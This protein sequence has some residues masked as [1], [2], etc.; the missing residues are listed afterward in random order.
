MTG[1]DH[2][3]TYIDNE[4]SL[5]SLTGQL[6]DY[7]RVALDTEADS[8]YHYHEKVCLI[9]LAGGRDVYIVDPL[10]GIDLTAFFSILAG[11]N[12]ILH[13]ADYDL[14]MLRASF[15]FR[16]RAPIFDTMLAARLLGYERLGLAALTDGILGVSLSK[17]SQ[18]FNWSRRPLPA[19]KLAYAGDDTRYLEQLA[20]NLIGR[21]RQL[22]REDWHR[23]SCE[24]LVGKTGTD[25]PT[26]KA[27]E[28]WRIKGSG[29]L[30]REEL[31]VL[32]A[33]WHWRDNEADNADI[34]PFKVMGNAAILEL[35]RREAAHTGPALFRGIR[36]PRTC[37]GERLRKLERAVRET[38]NLPAERL[39]V[40]RIKRS[41]PEPLSGPEA[42]RL[43]ILRT[44]VFQLAGSLGLSP[45]VLAPRTALEAVIRTGAE[46]VDEI[47]ANSDLLR[48]QARLLAPVI[49]NY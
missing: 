48:W 35:A 19:E 23:E 31:G 24:A 41:R 17:G 11:K 47:M 49:R 4:H 44:A 30:S 12:L 39:P 34:P 40:R 42:A 5:G 2:R 36:L 20:D 45:P 8:L 22:G 38:R 9:Q 13:D 25:R 14:R 15:G 16:P 3:Y 43:E 6:A 37:R 7:R 26:A 1:T 21:L 46:T 28:I 27:D 18:K 10:A 29:L 32:R 33:V